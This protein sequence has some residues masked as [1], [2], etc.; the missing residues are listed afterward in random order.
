MV[1][2]ATIATAISLINTV[3]WVAV[4]FSTAGPMMLSGLYEA[5]LDRR[6][7]SGMLKGVRTESFTGKDGGRE[8][9]YRR[10]GGLYVVLV[11]N[12]EF[13]K[14][15][16]ADVGE[17]VKRAV[18]KNGSGEDDVDSGKHVENA[19]TPIRSTDKK[20]IVERSVWDDINTLVKPKDLIQA[21]DEEKEMRAKDKTPSDEFAKKLTDLQNNYR[22]TTETRLKA[23]LDC[24]ASFG[25]V[26]GA[27]VVFFVGSFL[28][29]VIQNLS[30]VG[31][32]DTSHAL[33]FGMW[34]MIVPHVA[35]VS[36][37][38]LAGNNPN[39]LEVIMCSVREPWARQEETAKGWWKSWWQRFYSSV[40]VPVRM[41]E[42]GMNKRLWVRRL[43]KEYPLSKPGTKKEE[44]SEKTDA[45]KEEGNEK[46]IER[47]DREKE[48]EDELDIEF[49]F[50][51]WVMMAG[52][53][54][55]LMGLPFILAF[56]T[57]FYTPAVGLSCRT[58]TFLLYFCFQVCYMMIWGWEFYA[59]K[60]TTLWRTTSAKLAQSTNR[61]ITRNIERDI[62][63]NPKN[64]IRSPTASSN[65]NPGISS[66]L[67]TLVHKLLL[68]FIILGSFFTSVFGTFF[69]LVGLYRNCRCY[70]PIKYWGSGDFSFGISSNT[71]DGIAWAR[72]V[73]LPTGIT[74][75]VLMIVTCYIGWWYQRHW[76]LQFREVV[77][78]LLGPPKKIVVDKDGKDGKDGKK[79]GPKRPKNL[80]DG[81]EGSWV[82]VPVG[83]D[84]SKII[85][86]GEGK[87]VEKK[88]VV[89]VDEIGNASGEGVTPDSGKSLPV[90][91]PER[92]E[93]VEEIGP[94]DPK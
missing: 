40:Y 37:C 90:K 38:L 65:D 80:K 76:R 24:Q 9:F 63:K 68:G 71:K 85:G 47:K 89:G 45:K 27:A 7:V 75:I 18:E 72:K 57:S 54:V 91:N 3:F 79:K 1:V 31:D 17:E 59:M 77:K 28:F 19:I 16:T 32:N 82:F 69:Q 52:I 29:S 6:V 22:R 88:S 41:V 2:R 39:T 92:D 74:S 87:G 78:L 30:S 4:V 12:L 20:D 50:W 35:I 62:E 93:N 84:I 60:P 64:P 53:V 23:M 33:A 86:G 73:W 13:G 49:D 26:V 66:Q 81:H 36:G 10:V 44:G 94:A 56:L 55:F 48:E 21:E 11:G 83:T 51:D 14:E 46:T 25:A 15:K 67:S 8:K 61:V 70:M 5:R 34:W 42:R 58:F 43:V